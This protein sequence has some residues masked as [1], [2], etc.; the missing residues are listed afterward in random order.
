MAIQIFDNIKRSEIIDFLKE[1]MPMDPNQTYR[2]VIEPE[3]EYSEEVQPVEELITEETI[4]AVQISSKDHQV[5]NYSEC[6]N[7]SELNHF[8]IKLKM[9]LYKTRFPKSIQQNLNK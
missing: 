7:E 2:I 1:K 6:R 5:K 4:L 3:Q 8:S 9:T